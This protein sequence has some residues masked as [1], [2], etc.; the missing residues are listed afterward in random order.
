MLYAKEIFLYT[1][2]CIDLIYVYPSVYT[3]SRRYKIDSATTFKKIYLRI[4]L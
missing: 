1:P 4:A 3:I 2:L